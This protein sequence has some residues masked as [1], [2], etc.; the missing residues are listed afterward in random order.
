MDTEKRNKNDAV[1][2]G[3][4]TSRLQFDL[5]SIHALY[6]TYGCNA[7]YRDFTPDHLIAVD[8]NMIKE[9][10]ENNAHVQSK[11]HIQGHSEF[12]NHIQRK[13]YEIIW[14]GLREALDSGNSAILV[15]AQ[16]KHTKIYL[17]GFD[18]IN[19]DNIMTNVYL[20]TRNYAP[21]HQN[22]MSMRLPQGW[23]KRLAK[24]VKRFKDTQF[25][26]VNA[27]NISTNITET[28]YSEI[29]KEQFK[30]IINA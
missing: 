6:T 9:I 14:Y 1:V 20:N 5:D 24:L 15:A 2:I 29:T 25:I 7:L 18:Y 16:H 8:S 10:L 27:N 17:I 19:S 12:D 4:G 30:E 26:R 11:L 3:N 13:N 23:I 22:E 28:N 21:S